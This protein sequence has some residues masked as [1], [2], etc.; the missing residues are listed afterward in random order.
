MAIQIEKILLETPD[1]IMKIDSLKKKIEP[2]YEEKRF[3]EDFEEAILVMRKLGTVRKEENVV[4]LL[5]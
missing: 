3:N 5:K 2:I 1:K 4:I